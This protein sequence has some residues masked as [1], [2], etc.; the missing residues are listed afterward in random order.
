MK[1][2][3]DVAKLVSAK[4][5]LQKAETAQKS[6]SSRSGP[7]LR[8]MD[9]KED[10]SKIVLPD[11]HL[12]TGIPTVSRVLQDFDNGITVVLGQP[13][14]GKT[15]FVVQLQMDLLKLNDDAIVIDVSLDDS[16]KKRWV[17][18]ISNRSGLG[19]TYVSNPGIDMPK[20]FEERK[21]RAM[22]Q[23]YGW[24]AEERLFSFDQQEYV[25]DVEVGGH[26][27]QVQ[28]GNYHSIGNLMR[29]IRETYPNSKPVLFIDAWNDVELSETN[30][31]EVSAINKDI[32]K[33]S[34]VS[35][36]TSIPIIATSHTTK[37]GAQFLTLNDISG[38]K[39]MHYRC[40][41]GFVLKNFYAEDPLNDPLMYSDPMTGK[42]YPVVVME[43]G[44]N[45]ESPWRFPLIYAFDEFACRFISFDP[46]TYKRLLAEYK[47]RRYDVQEKS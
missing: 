28:V 18:W 30:N 38:S 15:T 5:M 27:L 44:K 2:T 37:A 41:A 7:Y 46:P 1:Q 14:S 12:K 6:L 25:H 20:E 16:F 32:R 34:Q 33:L 17:Q 39:G 36:E 40:V 19:Y 4:L 47:T 35:K 24:M 22:H 3:H 31:S 8:F 10:D 29:H 13:H 11:P 42:E 43:V 45:K 26:Q 9:E 21:E 23:L